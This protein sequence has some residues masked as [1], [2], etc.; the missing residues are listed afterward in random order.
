M[1]NDEHRLPVINPPA[2]ESDDPSCSPKVYVSNEEAALLAEM[3]ELREASIE[4]RRRLKSPEGDERSALET[5]LEELR[6][7]REEVAERRERAFTR[8]MI[9]LGHLPPDHPVER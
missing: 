8:K 1:S 7:Q 9:M 4:V 5:R 6:R 2:E 3:R